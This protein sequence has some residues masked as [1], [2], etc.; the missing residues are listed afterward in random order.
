MTIEID[1]QRIINETI[2]RFGRLDV[3]VNNAGFAQITSILDPQSIV[4]FDRVHSLDVRSL[5]N[6]TLLAV[7]H[8]TKSK[9]N[10]VNISSICAL[11]PVRLCSVCDSLF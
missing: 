1:S 9:G 7:P 8:L 2:D 4:N 5:V 6:L 10:I 3:L 11:K